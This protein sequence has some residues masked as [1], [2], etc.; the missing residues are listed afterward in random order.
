MCIKRL[1]TWA[2]VFTAIGTVAVAVMAIWGD[3]I[4]ALLVG[5]RLTLTLRNGGHVV[6]RNDETNQWHAIFYHMNVANQRSW[7]PARKVQVLVT[8][9]AKQRPDG[10]FF[11]ENVLPLQLTW[12]N[13]ELGVERFPTVAS[14]SI[15]DLGYLDEREHVFRLRTYASSPTYPGSISGG[16]AMRVTLVASAENGNSSQVTVEISWDGTWVSDENAIQKHLVVK[17]VTS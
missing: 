8:G 11:A 1:D 5:P 16:E 7:S 12:I 10:S 4:R 6:A 3:W 9:I 13:P 2:S 15:C 14:P 17:E